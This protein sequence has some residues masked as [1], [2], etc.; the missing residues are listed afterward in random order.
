MHPPPE[1]VE[2]YRVLETI[3][4]EDGPNN[5][6]E[7]VLLYQPEEEDSPDCLL[8]AT[9]YY[10][11]ESKLPNNHNKEQ[12]SILGTGITYP[13]ST[14]NNSLV[15]L[16]EAPNEVIQTW[17]SQPNC[18]SVKCAKPPSDPVIQD[19]L[20]CYDEVKNTLKLAENYND[21]TDVA[22]RYLGT[23]KIYKTD[24]FVPEPSIPIYSNSHTPGQIVGGPMVDTLIDTGASKC[25]MSKQFYLKHKCR[26][27]L[28]KYKSKIVKLRVGNGEKVSAHFVVPIVLKI[29]QHNVEIFTLVSDIQN[30]LDLVIGMK[31]LHELEA[32]HSCRHSELR[33]LNRAVPMFPFENFSLKPGHKRY[34]KFI[35]PFFQF[36][37]GKAIVKL[38]IGPHVYM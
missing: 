21:N 3:L 22:T 27:N 38:N 6:Y 19:Y 37:N 33:F 28:P 32:E 35:V 34:V 5:P 13:Q 20:D 9:D 23:D 17:S 15:F 18:P 10:F 25:Y 14:Y 7:Q 2:A 4:E 31:N 29:Q 24:H 16:Q 30:N 12:W 1:D 8:S 36:L 11:P 26:H